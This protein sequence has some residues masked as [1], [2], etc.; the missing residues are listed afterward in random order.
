[1]CDMELI[2]DDLLS[3]KMNVKLYVFGAPVV[4]WISGHVN[5]DAECDRH[6]GDLVE[7]LAKEVAKPGTFGDGIGDGSILSLGA[8]PRYCTLLFR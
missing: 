7:Q 6:G 8:G 4:H 1:M 3:N 2:N 5:R